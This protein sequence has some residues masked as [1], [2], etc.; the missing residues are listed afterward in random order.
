MMTVRYPV[1][2]ADIKMQLMLPAELSAELEGLLNLGI[3][4]ICNG[5]GAVFD[6]KAAPS[7]EALAAA[8]R[9][10]MLWAEFLPEVQRLIFAKYHT[11]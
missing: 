3:V 5:Y 6:D 9:H 2:V 11:A 4:T 8:R 10:I 7:A 1:C